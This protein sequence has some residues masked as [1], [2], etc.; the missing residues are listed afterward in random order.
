MIDPEGRTSHSPAAM[1]CRR[2]NST[3]LTESC[4]G[5]VLGIATTHVY[6]P[7]AA[8]R[9]PVSIVSAS[10]LPG[11][12]RWVWRSTNPGDTTWPAASITCSPSIAVRVFGDLAHEAVGDADVGAALAGRVDHSR[13]R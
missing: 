4:V 2:T 13:R 10:S 5:S 1:P 7:L 6:P 12:R 8:A 11:S 3:T 9:E